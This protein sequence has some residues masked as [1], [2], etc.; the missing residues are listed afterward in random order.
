MTRWY[1]ELGCQL[2]HE[3]EWGYQTKPG[4]CTHLHL[5]VSKC[6]TKQI[7]RQA[8]SK[9]RISTQRISDRIRMLNSTRS[10]QP[11]AQAAWIR[12][13]A[14]GVE[15]DKPSHTHSSSQPS[16][17]AVGKS[18]NLSKLQGFKK[19]T[20]SFI[21]EGWVRG[22]GSSS[23]NPLPRRL[24]YVGTRNPITWVTTVLPTSAWAASL[25]TNWG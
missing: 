2:T 8:Y 23:V 4:I 16:R 22:K 3:K 13:R 6:W 10:Q 5:P 25:I 11:D 24:Q 15:P 19:F 17:E 21:W 7:P 14:T 1:M 9:P 12:S 20:H 18:F